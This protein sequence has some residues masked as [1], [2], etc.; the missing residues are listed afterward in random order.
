MY[1]KILIPLDGSVEAEGVLPMVRGLVTPE[2]E[3]ILF[4][5]V[6]AGRSR[7]FGEYTV[8]RE[9]IRYLRQVLG[10]LG[11]PEGQWRCEAAVFAAAADGI[12]DYARSEEVDLI[13]MCSQDRKGLSKLMKGSIAEKVRKKTATE[14][15]VFKPGELVA[16]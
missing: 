12:V 11:E 14:V 7:A 15:Q 1:R 6:S 8:R 4:Q 16:A 2:S 3:V 5:V 9:A 13:A 10:K